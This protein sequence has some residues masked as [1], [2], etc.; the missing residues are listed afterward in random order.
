VSY[1]E[2]SIYDFNRTQYEISGKLA[3]HLMNGD[4]RWRY[5]LVD[6]IFKVRKY[7][8]PFP[9]YEWQIRL[10]PK[11]FPNEGVAPQPV[12][13]WYRVAIFLDCAMTFVLL[14]TVWFLCEWLIRRRA[15]SS[16]RVDF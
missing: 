16:F 4:D 10:T 2:N 13:N 14:A 5:Y 7:G 8:W 15:A 9:V 11:D 1:H 6:P 12:I 3:D